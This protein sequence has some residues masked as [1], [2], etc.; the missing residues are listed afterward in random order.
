VV[1][2]QFMRLVR[3][4]SISLTTARAYIAKRNANIIIYYCDLL[5]ARRYFDK[6]KLYNRKLELKSSRS[7][8]IYFAI[9]KKE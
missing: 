7:C 3:N 8:K 5:A 4:S 6:A 9:G 2:I 1:E